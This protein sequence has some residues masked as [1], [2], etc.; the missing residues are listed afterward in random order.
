M[1]SDRS[2]REKTCMKGLCCQNFLHPRRKS[3]CA[4]YSESMSPRTCKFPGP[5]DVFRRVPVQYRSRIAQSRSFEKLHRANPKLGVFALNMSVP[6]PCRNKRPC[7]IKR[8]FRIT[9][10]GPRFLHGCRCSAA[11]K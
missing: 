11:M 10:L 7:C 9:S 3:W 4:R 2:G 8:T 5:G 6:V 1:A